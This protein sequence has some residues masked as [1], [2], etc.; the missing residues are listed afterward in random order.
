[1]RGWLGCG[2][3]ARQR[4]R[5]C[6]RGLA[7]SG[8]GGDAFLQARQVGEGQA[9]DYAGIWAVHDLAYD[10]EEFLEFVH[11]SSAGGDMCEKR[12]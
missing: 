1:V 4:G 12:R 7:G 10:M 6:Q 5:H 3:G 11:A 8:S 2:C 9:G